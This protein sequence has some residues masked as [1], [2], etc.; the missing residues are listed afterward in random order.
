MSR[1]PRLAVLILSA[2]AFCGSSAGMAL[3]VEPFH[4]WYFCFAWWA[5]ILGL[6][7]ALAL[8]GGESLLWD[9]PGEWLALLPLSLVLWLFFELLNFRLDNWH[10]LG[11]PLN[12]A[13]RWAGYALSFSTVLPGL[14]ATAALL[15]RLR[16]FE[17]V[18][19]APL[20]HPERLTVPLV[21]GGTVLMVL[22]MQAPQWFFPLV[23][24]GLVPLLDPLA[25]MLGGRSLLADWERGDPRR[26]LRLLAAGLICGGLWETWNFWA[27]AKWAYTVPLV[28]DLKLFEMPVLGY[29]GFPPFALECAVAAN[30][31]FALRERTRL[32]S[33]P[34]RRLLTFAVLALAALFCALVMSGIDR[35]TVASFRP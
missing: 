31:F 25:A 29:L 18:E 12:G 11:V 5:Y 32:L 35:H 19:V 15:D 24:V 17:A 21:L 13:A 1:A 16:V 30:L 9:R 6:E 23:W 2:L 14:F 33:G 28:G 27:G 26:A 8:S 34:R 20:T 22:P 7:S 10:Y 3:G 4:T